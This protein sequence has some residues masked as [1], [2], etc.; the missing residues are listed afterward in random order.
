MSGTPYPHSVALGEGA[1]DDRS[2]DVDGLIGRPGPIAD[3]LGN[4]GAVAQYEAD[5]ADPARTRR[6]SSLEGTKGPLPQF[7]PMRDILRISFNLH[8]LSP[9]DIILRRLARSTRLPVDDH[10]ANCLPFVPILGAPLE[11]LTR[12]GDLM[13]PWFRRRLD[14]SGDEL[15]VV[16][17]RKRS[18]DPISL[19]I[20][21]YGEKG[22]SGFR[23][24]G[25]PKPTRSRVMV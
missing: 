8:D 18:F 4:R 20:V 3:Q 19:L 5:I 1:A 13:L 10:L 14:V 21:R 17:G 23:A 25:R 7:L 22:T 6:G 16:Y 12:Y 11:F 15:R 2:D 24:G 9:A